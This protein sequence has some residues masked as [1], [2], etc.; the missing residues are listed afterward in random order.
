MY[1]D[2]VDSQARAV[3]PDILQSIFQ[4]SEPCT[5]FYLVTHIEPSRGSRS[6]CRKR[7]ASRYAFKILWAR[8]KYHTPDMRFYYGL[9][10]RNPDTTYTLGW[11]FELRMHELL[12]Q[13]NT[14]QLLPIYSH[15]TSTEYKI[16]KA[17]QLPESREHLLDEGEQLCVGHYYQ[18]QTTDFSTIDSLFFI[19]PPD[20][21]SPIL[22]AFQIRHK[23]V[24]DVE[25]EDLRR[26]DR[27]SS[28]HTNIRKFFVVVTP[29]DIQPPLE[30]LKAFFGGP[31]TRRA[32][33]R[34]ISRKD[35]QVFQY[36]V[37]MGGLFPATKT[38][39]P[40]L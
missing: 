15:L 6:T 36:P 30:A 14:I 12:R 1:R 38:M 20:E 32:V 21:P 5:T 40:Q 37:D 24:C 9:L 3:P 27:L 8:L 34:W 25:V 2:L 31:M 17:I 28:S 23:T 39:K 16:Q 33:G 22:L 18:L 10:Q 4:A 35:W 11:I 26:V 13:G 29:D 19:H 7:I